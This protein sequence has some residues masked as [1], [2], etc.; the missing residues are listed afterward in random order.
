MQRYEDVRTLEKFWEL[1]ICVRHEGRESPFRMQW[2]TRV[3]KSVG[4]GITQ[5][6]ESQ[7]HRAPS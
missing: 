4:S 5:G 7:A 3:E 1:Q 6:Q 2:D